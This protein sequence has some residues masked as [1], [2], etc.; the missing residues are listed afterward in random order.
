[1]ES[2]VDQDWKG[3]PHVSPAAAVEETAARL[4]EA[5]D[6]AR[7]LGIDPGGDVHVAHFG[8]VTVRL[9]RRLEQHSWDWVAEAVCGDSVGSRVETYIPAR[10]ISHWAWLHEYWR[11][12][13]P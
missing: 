7:A 1:M 4:D 11:Q 5:I 3:W 13:R 10:A 6:E 9:A 12:A 8:A 2:V